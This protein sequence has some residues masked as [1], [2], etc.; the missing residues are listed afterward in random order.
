MAHFKLSNIKPKFRKAEF[1]FQENE[2]EWLGNILQS[3]FFN[4]LSVFIPASER[5]VSTII[6]Q[7]LPFIAD[8]TLAQNA[9]VFI[10]QEGRHAF[11]HKQCNQL[12][13]KR[14]PAL[15]KIERLQIKVIGVLNKLITVNFRRS[16]PVSFEHF[17][18]NISR[19]FL[20]NQYHWTQGNSNVYID[21]LHWHC[22]EEL[23]HQ[24][25]CFDVYRHYHRNPL[26]I[27]LCLL[28]FWLP[29]TIF[30][31]YGVQAYLLIKDKHLNHPKHWW[32]FIKFI[33]KTSH[34]FYGGTFKYLKK[35]YQP[36]THADEVLYRRNLPLD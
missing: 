26:R 20:T 16:I 6:Q 30:S 4:A 14:Y 10:Q 33:K 12:L 31:V 28:F 2:L 29:I 36:W 1:H 13:K 25:V 15:A 35:D 34:L 27:P 9:K 22:L 8:P 21:F 5:Y 18:A 19:E 23:E 24:A 7:Q 11:L 3:H 32:G 17:T